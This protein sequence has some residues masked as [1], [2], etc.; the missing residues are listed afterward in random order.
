MPQNPERPMPLLQ[1]PVQVTNKEASLL[2][3]DEV[4]S[5]AGCNGPLSMCACESSREKQHPI[6]ARQILV[7]WQFLPSLHLQDNC[8]IGTR[9]LVRKR[10]L[11]LIYPGYLRILG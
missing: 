11:S 5:K 10:I 8:G 6:L 4:N 3:A 9:A 2:Q 7:R 1:E